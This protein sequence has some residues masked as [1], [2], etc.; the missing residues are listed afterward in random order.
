VAR[1]DLYTS[2]RGDFAVDVQADLLEDF[3]RRV[4]V[5]LLPLANVPRPR[6]DLHPTFL[7]EGR[8]V[9]MATHYISSVRRAELGRPKANLA[10]YRDDI[11]RALDMLFTGF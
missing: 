2:A 7:V 6:K 4:V 11:T 8:M 10:H 1:F 5:P 9:V 3:G